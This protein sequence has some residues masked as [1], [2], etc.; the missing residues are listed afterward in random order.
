MAACL[1]AI[2]RSDQPR[3]FVAV[4]VS[5]HPVCR[6]DWLATRHLDDD[7]IEADA[8]RQV[9]RD[10]QT[11]REVQR[12]ALIDQAAQTTESRPRSVGS[13]DTDGSPIY[14][15]DTRLAHVFGKGR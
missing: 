11:E 14:D 1:E 9:L 4:V 6:A 10:D 13:Y 15:D 8:E 3:E 5:I 7:Q 12:Q 2:P